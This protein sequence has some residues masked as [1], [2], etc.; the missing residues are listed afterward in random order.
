MDSWAAE[1]GEARAAD[2]AAGSSLL[3]GEPQAD[4]MSLVT[5]TLDHFSAE[6][7][8][9][10]LY[11]QWALLPLRSAEPA[12]LQIEAWGQLEA[13][14]HK[15][16]VDP[17]PPSRL[18]AWAAQPQAPAA[19]GDRLLELLE[20]SLQR[21]NLSR[22]EGADTSFLLRWALHHLAAAAEGGR[23]PLLAARVAEW[24]EAWRRVA[25]AGLE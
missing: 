23:A 13:L 18:C 4:V 3:G 25:A 20:H 7:L 11:T 22:A 15:L 24:P 17:P 19:D 1:G 14:A 16:C 10:P 6:S 9:D 5:R 2:F 12:A 21:G 8:G